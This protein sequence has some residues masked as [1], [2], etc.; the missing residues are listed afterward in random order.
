MNLMTGR[1]VREEDYGT[2]WTLYF[3]LDEPGT[4]AQG[5]YDLEIE[6]PRMVY[7]ILEIARDRPWFPSIV[8]RSTSCRPMPVVE[9]TQ[10]RVARGERAARRPRS[11][12]GAARSLW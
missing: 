9:L 3:R 10:A 11:R 5:D 12:C 4:T 2:T 6:V 1:V 7:E 8:A